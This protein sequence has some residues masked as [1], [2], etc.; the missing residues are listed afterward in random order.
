MIKI[1]IILSVILTISVGI[2]IWLIVGNGIKIN[3][4]YENKVY[5]NNSQGQISMNMYMSNGKVIYTSKCFE[6]PIERLN[7]LNSIS[8]EKG[9]LSKYYEYA[10]GFFNIKF[11]YCID[12]F[13]INKDK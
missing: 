7:Y 3:N 1:T 10:D 4:N 6:T 8:T 2:N 11:K 5:N 9:V 13:S 12:E